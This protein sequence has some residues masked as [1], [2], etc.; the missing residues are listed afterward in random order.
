[1]DADKFHANCYSYSAAVL[2]MHY[3]L[4]QKPYRIMW[5]G[6]YVSI[7]GEFEKF[8]EEEDLLGISTY[9]DLSCFMTD[10]KE[11]S[12][13]YCNKVK[14]IMEN[15]KLWNR[16]NVW[17]EAKKY[18]DW[19][20]TKSVLY[21]GYLVNHTKKKA[22]DLAA[23]YAQ[24]ISLFSNKSE[25]AIDL[26]PPLTETGGGLEMALFDGLS[27]DSTEQF[28]GI[29]RSDLL[30]IVNELPSGYDLIRCC[31]A[32]VYR[33]ALYCYNKFGVDKENLVLADSDGRKFVA[34]PISFRMTRGRPSFMKIEIDDDGI[35]YIP[36]DCD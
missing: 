5:G 2:S 29:W 14:F 26:I 4:R 3:L 33:R 15:N 6:H 10:D 23:Y 32:E 7:D 9:N 34:A 30:Q 28:R 18:F 19:K 11:H 31:F 22:V 21:S 17:E 24:S 13:S 1:M 12:E 16:I 25:Y 27:T 35:S 8:N 20:N 36:V